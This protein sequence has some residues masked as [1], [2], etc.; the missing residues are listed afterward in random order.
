MTLAT[1]CATAAND[2]RRLRKKSNLSAAIELFQ[3]TVVERRHRAVKIFQ[4]RH[5][6]ISH[7]ANG[8][9]P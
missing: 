3:P 4:A 7:R 5:R 6:D 1:S 8:Y 2:P 9:C